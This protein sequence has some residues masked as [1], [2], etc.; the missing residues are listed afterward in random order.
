MTRNHCIDRLLW[1]KRT[2]REVRECLHD[3]VTAWLYMDVNMTDIKSICYAV[4]AT[5]RLNG[6]I[7]ESEGTELELVV[8]RNLYEL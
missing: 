3:A 6:I 4:I 2:F 8:S 5:A 7:S 1:R